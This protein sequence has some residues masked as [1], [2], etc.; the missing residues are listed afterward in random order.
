M[1]LEH[2]FRI[3]S[4]QENLSSDESPPAW[5]WPLDWEIEAWFE[6]VKIEREKKYGGGKSSSSSDS[7]PEG[8]FDDNLYFE[9]LKNGENIWE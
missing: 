2:A 4:W 7:E 5:M 9:R 1:V 3:L 6:K 8:L